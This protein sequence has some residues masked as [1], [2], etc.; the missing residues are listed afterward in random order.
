MKLPSSIYVNK[1]SPLNFLMIKKPYVLLNHQ[2]RIS[3]D[4]H[5]IH[6]LLQYLFY[7]LTNLSVNNSFVFSSTQLTEICDVHSYLDCS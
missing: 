6:I 5:I 4:E 7:I 3:Y 1:I 2:T